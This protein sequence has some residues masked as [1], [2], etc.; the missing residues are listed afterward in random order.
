[1]KRIT[2]SFVTVLVLLISLMIQ[3]NN[4]TTFAENGRR[5]STL[6][7][8]GNAEELFLETDKLAPSREVMSQKIKI[9]NENDTPIKVK[10]ILEFVLKKEGLTDSQLEQMLDHYL[11]KI[12][13]D[14]SSITSDWKSVKDVNKVLKDFSMLPQNSSKEIHFNIKLSEAAGNEYQAANLNIRF[15]VSSQSN[16]PPIDGEEPKDPE[17][18]SNDQK[19]HIDDANGNQ[20]NHNGGKKTD[21]VL[22]NT[23]TILFKTLVIGIILVFLGIGILFFSSK[24]IFFSPFL[25]KEQK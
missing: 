10:G 23:A 13:L 1:M 15:T 5:S 4:N 18:P 17:S 19:Q 21:L 24:R 12:Y 7:L 22:P 16:F 2:L 14:N 25:R 8:R 11:I 20:E 3:E 6:T 9:K